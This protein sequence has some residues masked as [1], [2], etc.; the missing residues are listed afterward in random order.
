MSHSSWLVYE[1]DES[2]EPK[3]FAKC[4]ADDQILWLELLRYDIWENGKKIVMSYYLPTE[5]VC[6][7]H[8]VLFSFLHILVPW[9]GTP[10]LTLDSDSQT[11]ITHFLRSVW[12]L[13]FSWGTVTHCHH[14]A[15]QLLVSTVI[16]PSVVWYCN[17]PVPKFIFF[18]ILLEQR[19]CLGCSFV[20]STCEYGRVQFTFV[21]LCMFLL[22]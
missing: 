10:T 2:L 7:P 11:P 14:W 1:G 18:T 3:Q 13:T 15:P 9:L 20:F 8:G 16:R 17:L 6:Q 12:D 22:M 4:L 21:S 19:P 5:R